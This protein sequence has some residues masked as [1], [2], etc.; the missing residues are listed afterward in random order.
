MDTDEYLRA[1]PRTL[2]SGF[3]KDGPQLPNLLSHGFA[4]DRPQLPRTLST[5]FAGERAG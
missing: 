5:G 3:V 1:H 2:A 4:E